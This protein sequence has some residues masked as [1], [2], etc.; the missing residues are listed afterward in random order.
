LG[1]ALSLYVDRPGGS[2]FFP[3]SIYLSTG[4]SPTLG[5]EIENN[6]A[7]LKCPSDLYEPGDMP[8]LE[9]LVT[10]YAYFA[11]WRTREQLMESH[12]KP[13]T[14]II[15]LSDHE[16]FHGGVGESSHNALFLDGHVGTGIGVKK[17]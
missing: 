7:L 6:R 17:R 15:I 4:D 8:N 5:W 11:G 2:G 3:S 9:R 10:S 16:P 12:E 14:E 13:S 1:V